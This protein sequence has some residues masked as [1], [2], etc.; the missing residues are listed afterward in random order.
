[1]PNPGSFPGSRGEFLKEQRERYAQ[2]VVDGNINDV[3][4]EIQ[5]RYFKRY[6][7][8]LPHEEEP[9]QEWLSQVDDDAPD[10][11][12]TPPVVDGM[13]PEAASK[14]LQ[15][16]AEL[17]KKLKDRKDVGQTSYIYDYLSLYL[18]YF[19]T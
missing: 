3:V 2:A 6:P 10:P 11:E 5:R 7:I 9:S 12:I 1:M 4:T 15:E 14:A 13:S 18:I 8:N 17:M 19:L 16:H